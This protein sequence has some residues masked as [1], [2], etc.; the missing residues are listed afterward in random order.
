MKAKKT[1]NK[2]YKI[3]LQLLRCIILP[4][5]EYVNIKPKQFKVRTPL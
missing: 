4:K 1:P 5:Y 2:F 3:N